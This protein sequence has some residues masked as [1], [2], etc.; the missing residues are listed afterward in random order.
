[1]QT[2]QVLKTWKVSRIANLFGINYS[3]T[4]GKTDFPGVLILLLVLLDFGMIS[5]N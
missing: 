2:F 3:L 5:N 4:P 1:M